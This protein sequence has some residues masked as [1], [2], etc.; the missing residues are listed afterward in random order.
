M[1]PWRVSRSILDGEP[2]RRTTSLPE[3]MAPSAAR[4]CCSW[5]VGEL[6]HHDLM[7]IAKWFL[8]S[9]YWRNNR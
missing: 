9:K 7:E 1:R 4:H 8:Q 2:A 3:P 6:M 5:I